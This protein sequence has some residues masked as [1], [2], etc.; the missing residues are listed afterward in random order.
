MDPGISCSKLSLYGC[1]EVTVKWFD[2]FLNGRT[3]R[4][5]VVLKVSNEISLVS[6]IPQ[7]GVLSPLVFVLYVSDLEDWLE[8]SSAIT[9]A[10]DSTTGTYQS[11]L[12]NQIRTRPSA[13]Q[14][15]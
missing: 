15:G 9:Y 4:L 8:C 7:G 11:G 3:Q 12:K 13:T 1:D 14:H 10:D 6:G 5:K 2:S